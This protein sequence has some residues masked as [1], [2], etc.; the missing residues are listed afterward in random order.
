M[1]R[2]QV[3]LKLKLGGGTIS[4]FGLGAKA[5]SMLGI[6]ALAAA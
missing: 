6:R 5:V 4:L 2:L 1:V 3:I